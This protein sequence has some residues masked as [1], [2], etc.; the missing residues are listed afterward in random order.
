MLDDSATSRLEAIIRVEKPSSTT[1]R[2][3]PRVRPGTSSPANKATTAVTVTAWPANASDTPISPPMGVSKLAGRY[4]AVNKPNTP[5]ASENTAIQAAEAGA[6]SPAL[7]RQ[8]GGAVSQT[9]PFI[10]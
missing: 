10:T 6:A 2:S 7:P 9:Q 5:I 3:S 4:S 1:R 8:A